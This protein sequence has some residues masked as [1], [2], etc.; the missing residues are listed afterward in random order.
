VKLFFTCLILENAHKN[1]EQV[2]N[3]FIEKEY[4]VRIME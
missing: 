1:H 3:S 4:F 2:Y